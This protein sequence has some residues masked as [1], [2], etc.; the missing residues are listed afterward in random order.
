VCVLSKENLLGGRRR[1]RREETVLI[2]QTKPIPTVIKEKKEKDE[3][4]R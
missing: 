2:G 3:D 4:C 1:K